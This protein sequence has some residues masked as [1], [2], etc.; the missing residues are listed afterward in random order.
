[1]MDMNSAI[2]EFTKALKMKMEGAPVDTDLD[3]YEYQQL[4]AE[5]GED[6]CD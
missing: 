1:M 2:L 6:Y 4:L 3:D 5:F